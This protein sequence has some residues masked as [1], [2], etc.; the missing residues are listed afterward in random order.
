M[1]LTI[2]AVACPN[3]PFAGERE[4]RAGLLRFARG[5]EAQ[6]D[7][8]MKAILLASALLLATFAVSSPNAAIAQEARNVTEFCGVFQG[9]CRRTCPGGQD[10]STACAERASRCRS[11]GCFHF[12]SPGPRC[13]NNPSDRALTDVRL[14]PNPEAERKRRGLK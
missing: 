4:Y 2:A 14:A 1:G 13:F 12:N 7:W 3:L 9:V 5:I 6:G 10:C 11:S 8:V